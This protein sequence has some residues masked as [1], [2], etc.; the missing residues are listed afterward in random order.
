MI[1]TRLL[2]IALNEGGLH[3]LVL[4]FHQLLLTKMKI[5]IPHCG[6]QGP[7]ISLL[8]PFPLASSLIAAS[9]GPDSPTILRSLRAARPACF[10]PVVCFPWHKL[11]S[12]GHRAK[13]FS[14][15]PSTS[16]QLSAFLPQQL[17]NFVIILSPQPCHA[18]VLELGLWPTYLCSQHLASCRCS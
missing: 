11:S 5:H 18:H 7:I 14:T 2:E 10:C 8:L 3:V 13:L 15:L 17:Q 6:I 12:L 16:R 1:K 4:R 9:A